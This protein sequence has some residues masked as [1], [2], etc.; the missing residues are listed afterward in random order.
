MTTKNCTRCNHVEATYFVQ[1]TRTVK[2]T[3]GRIR[4]VCRR[5]RESNDKVLASMMNHYNA[6]RR[7]FYARVTNLKRSIRSFGSRLPKKVYV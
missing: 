5:C 2:K 4:L 1:Q 7:D 6:G 3:D